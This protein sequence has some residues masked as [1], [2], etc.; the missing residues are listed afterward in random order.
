MESGVWW[1]LESLRTINAENQSGVTS[2]FSTH[3]AEISS[4]CIP[5]INVEQLLHGGIIFPDTRMVA[6]NMDKLVMVAGRVRQP[7]TGRLQQKLHIS[8]NSALLLNKN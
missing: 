5:L 1:S 3:Q 7:T 6:V 2:F 4:R 8:M